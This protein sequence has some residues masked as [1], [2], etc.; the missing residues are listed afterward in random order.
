LIQCLDYW[1]HQIAQSDKV[2]LLKFL[3]GQTAFKYRFIPFEQLLQLLI[4]VPQ[5]PI[6]L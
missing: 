2:L 4:F 6:P 3:F 5:H 1:T